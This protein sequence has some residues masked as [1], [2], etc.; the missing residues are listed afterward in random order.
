MEQKYTQ[1]ALV[2][3]LIL[4]ATIS[5]SLAAQ[6]KSEVI[7]FVSKSNAGFELGMSSKIRRTPQQNQSDDPDF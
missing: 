4:S 5:G 6:N 7:A 2:V 1:W 3:L